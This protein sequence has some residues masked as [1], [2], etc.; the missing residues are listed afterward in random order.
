MNVIFLL[1]DTL[2]RE[3]LSPYHRGVGSYS[4]IQTPN[5]ERL[6]SRCVTFDNHWINSSPC[7]PA[8]RDLCTGR[9]EFPWRSWGP[10]ETFDV[11]WALTCRESNVYSALFTDHANLFD[12]GA[13]NYHVWYDH[14]ELV[15]GHFN[16]RCR[17]SLPITPG[18]RNQPY[19]IY[20]EGR[21][22]WA[23]EADSFVAR[24]LSN[25]CSWL[26]THARHASPFFLM[27]DEFDP[28]W[29][30]DPPE[31]YRSMYLEDQKLAERKLTTV[32]RSARSE[33]YTE[34]ELRW[35]NAQYAGKLTMVDRWLGTLLDTLDRHNLWEDTLLV[36]TTDHGE[37]LGEYG[38]MSKGGGF[39]YPLFS[40]IPLFVHHPKVAGGSRCSALTCTVDLHATTLSALGLPIDPHTHSRSLLPLLTGECLSIRNEVLYGWWGKGFYWTDGKRLLCKAPEHE[41]PLFQYGVNLG[42]KYV[43]LKPERFDR[44][45]NAEVGQFLPHTQRPVYRIPSDGL[46]YGAR[47]VDFD[48]IFDLVSDPTCLKNLWEDTA[49]RSELLPCL[50][51][52]MK[53]LQVPHEHFERLGLSQA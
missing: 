12:V 27:V 25:V 52:A 29:P 39:S 21:T 47:R 28:H 11:D 16:D 43:G 49:L 48:A 42:E 35:M 31:P 50:C 30:L 51:Q 22:T 15:R 36:V 13:E 34:D 3:K 18:R 40:R 19:K 41:G 26:D 24:N 1:C 46:C 8:R 5:F 32:Y 23:S 9:I 6:A 45:A 37:F 53:E 44:Y 7:M 33:D 17:T 2:V 4:H 38:Q 10:R 20:D 14:W